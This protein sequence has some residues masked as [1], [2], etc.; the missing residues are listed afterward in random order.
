MSTQPATSTEK[1]PRFPIGKF[2]RSAANLADHRSSIA[3]LALLPEKLRSAVHGL[4]DA[5]LDTPYRD[6]GWTL[7]QLVHHVADSH[8]NAYVRIRLALTEDW[9][10]IKPYDEKVWAELPDARTAPVSTSL[11]LIDA[12]H[13]RWTLLL[14]SLTEEQWQRGYIHPV[15]GRQTIAEA[16]ALYDWHSRH[17]VA[18]IEELRKS[19]SW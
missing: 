19:R 8:M 5:Q 6:G 12:L 4:G 2:S 1:D 9:P 11:S 17:H 14:R 13:E 15:N 3:V 16:A 10:T 7:R 18:H